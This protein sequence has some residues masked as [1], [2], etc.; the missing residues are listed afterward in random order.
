MHLIIQSPYISA[1]LQQEL[2]SGKQKILENR[3]PVWPVSLDNE[4]IHSYIFSF[5]VTSFSDTEIIKYLKEML[6]PSLMKSC[7]NKWSKLFIL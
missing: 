7:F 1:A 2:K 5:A 4:S 6:P 3:A